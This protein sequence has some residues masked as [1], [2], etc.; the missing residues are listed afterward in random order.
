MTIK[1]LRFALTVLKHGKHDQ[2]SHGRRGSG[3]G[4]APA[5]MGARPARPSLQQIIDT[6]RPY[7]DL[8]IDYT[9][10]QMK[11]MEQ[12]LQNMQ[13]HM[14]R[15]EQIRSYHF[16]SDGTPKTPT[17][18]KECFDELLVHAKG[19]IRESAGIESKIKYPNSDQNFEHISVEGDYR[20]HSNRMRGNHTNVMNAITL[21]AWRQSTPGT[22]PD[23]L[24]NDQSIEQTYRAVYGEV[25]TLFD[26]VHT[27]PGD[28]NAPRFNDR[29]IEL[30]S[31]PADATTGGF[32]AGVYPDENGVSNPDTIAKIGINYDVTDKKFIPVVNHE[33]VHLI[34]AM[35]PHYI[36]AD[37]QFLR[38][39]GGNYLDE[40]LSSEG[41]ET[42]QDYGAR[43]H[44][45]YA[46]TVYYR[47]Q[48]VQPN[49]AT[50]MYRLRPMATEVATTT[51]ENV[52]GYARGSWDTVKDVSKTFTKIPDE[53]ALTYA[54]FNS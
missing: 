52:F 2:S 31:N 37:V 53:A 29:P 8:P 54:L 30:V 36:E 43:T 46:S 6:A 38:N 22:V 10:E 33:A 16:N 39:R 26:Y 13:R 49:E 32:F 42:Y 40:K 41:Y 5:T 14:E 12:Y 11:A 27:A 1:A 7:A 17:S 9:P 45:P 18:R 19:I 24:I 50:S 25:F 23:I 3:G 20:E 44:Y 21:E 28:E 51:A 47:G 48:R 15:T 4:L 34:Q 35:K